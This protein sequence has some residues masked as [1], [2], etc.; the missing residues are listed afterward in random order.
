MV[1]L[2]SDNGLPRQLRSVLNLMKTG[3]KQTK[4]TQEIFKSAVRTNRP[5]Q[6]LQPG[7]QGVCDGIGRHLSTPPRKTSQDWLKIIQHSAV[8]HASDCLDNGPVPRITRRVFNQAQLNP[9]ITTSTI[10]LQTP[11]RPRSANAARCFSQ[12]LLKQLHEGP[13]A[14]QHTSGL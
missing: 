6:N 8:P 7:K 10:C 13:V 14:R 5:S 4:G 2:L 3:V 1:D 12:C 11:N 9:R